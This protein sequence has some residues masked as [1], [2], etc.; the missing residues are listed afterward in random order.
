MEYTGDTQ[1][2]QGSSATVSIS[3]SA[4]AVDLTAATVTIYRLNGTVLINNAAAAGGNYTLTP[5][6][7]AQLD[8]LRFQWS[9]IY[10][11]QPWTANTFVEIVGD[12]LFT[13]AEAR[14]FD[15]KQLTNPTSYPDIAIAEARTRILNNFQRICNVA[16]VPRYSLKLL[17]SHCETELLLPDSK[18]SKLISLEF[19]DGVQWVA[20]D[21]SL[22]YITPDSCLTSYS[23]YQF[24]RHVRVGYEHGFSQTPQQLK[25][26]ALLV[27]VAELIPSN[28]PD[29]ALSWNVNGSQY[30]LSVANGDSRFYG[31]PAVD[32][33]LAL[34]SRSVIG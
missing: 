30:T 19:W 24:P 6:Q 34:Y 33:A 32:A 3:L 11:S 7:T 16:L 12:L 13:V 23:C 27:L 5:A 20:Q 28:L 21:T 10:N 22:Y 15:V 26:A 9:F 25:R 2:V 4:L 14:L 18:A 1:I 31:I 8:F 29:R 17:E